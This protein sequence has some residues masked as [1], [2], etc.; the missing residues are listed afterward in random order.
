MIDL[1]YSLFLKISKNLTVSH[2]R[3]A[4]YRGLAVVIIILTILGCAT[5]VSVFIWF[6]L[7]FLIPSILALT[8]ILISSLSLWAWGYLS[9]SLI[10]VACLVIPFTVNLERLPSSSR[11][12]RT[13][14]FLVVICFWLVL[15][16]PTLYVCIQFMR[17]GR[18]L[19]VWPTK[20]VESTSMPLADP[21]P[22]CP[23]PS[24]ASRSES[25]DSL[26]PVTA[27]EF[28]WIGLDPVED[29]VDVAFPP[30][31]LI[32]CSM[33]LLR[34]MWRCMRLFCQFEGS[35]SMLTNGTTT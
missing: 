32:G 23:L 20:Q 22:A 34:R 24:Y 35:V 1:I 8:A 30:V 25:P 16:T 17:L 19:L 13:A 5:L 15:A 2:R 3:I 7:E 26:Y 4:K 18:R 28:V 11:D 31:W 21:S 29:S 10:V 6:K 12:T 33:L 14:A 9:I 27:K